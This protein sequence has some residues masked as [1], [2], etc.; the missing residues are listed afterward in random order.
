MAQRSDASL[1]PSSCRSVWVV[2]TASNATR[3]TA[4]GPSQLRS[5]C[6]SPCSSLLYSAISSSF[7]SSPPYVSRLLFSSLSSCLGLSSPLDAIFAL[8]ASLGLATR[9]STNRTLRLR[10]AVTSTE[11]SLSE[12]LSAVR[13]N[14][15]GDERVCEQQHDSGGSGGDRSLFAFDNGVER[16]RER[17][18]KEYV[19]RLPIDWAVVTMALSD[20]RRHCSSHGYSRPSTVE[21]LCC[22]GCH[23]ARTIV[24]LRHTWRQV[25]H[26]RRPLHHLLV[27]QERRAR[28]P[29][30]QNLQPLSPVLPPPLHCPKRSVLVLCHPTTNPC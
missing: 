9:H 27:Q 28:P 20:D 7:V 17:F 1:S 4:A 16:D 30:P 25:S 11:D 6:T 5:C 19:A 14:N 13:L 12:Q 18:E 10:S 2:S 8:N 23:C 26:S 22:C 3:P 24:Q 21:R 15:D 29:L